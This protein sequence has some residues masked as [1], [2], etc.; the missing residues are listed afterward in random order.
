MTPESMD[1]PTLIAAVLCTRAVLSRISRLDLEGGITLELRGSRWT[2][3]RSGS[4]LTHTGQ[5][6][7][8]W[9]VDPLTATD[10]EIAHVERTGFALEDALARA[11]F[12]YS[13][14]GARSVLALA[15]DAP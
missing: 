10:D 11:G 5:W 12:V 14:P 15:E 3:G 13:A 8:A 1:R 4:L 7:T 6:E 2:I 9:H